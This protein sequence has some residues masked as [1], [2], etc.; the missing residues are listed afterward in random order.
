MT[1]ATFRT[2]KWFS[3]APCWEWALV[4]LRLGKRLR[5]SQTIWRFF[6]NSICRSAVVVRPSPTVQGKCS[7]LSPQSIWRAQWPLANNQLMQLLSSVHMVGSEAFETLPDAASPSSMLA[8]KRS[9]PAQRD[10]V[11]CFP[12]RRQPS[13]ALCLG[14]QST[15]T[16][17]YKASRHVLQITHGWSVSYFQRE[18]QPGITQGLKGCH[19]GGEVN[20]FSK[21]AESRA[22]SNGWSSSQGDPPWK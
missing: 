10:E 14:C 5:S 13:S 3:R 2:G 22:R 1:S 19:K 15:P 8:F 17:R 12:S 18:I 16:S 4:I 11:N 20:L 9:S 7:L 21:A 6:F